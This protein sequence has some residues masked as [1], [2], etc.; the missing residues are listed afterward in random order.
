MNLRYFGGGGDDHAENDE[1]DD[2]EMVGLLADTDHDVDMTPGPM[3]PTSS[4]AASKKKSSIKNK[5]SRKRG[6]RPLAVM[7]SSANRRLLT[8]SPAVAACRTG[9]GILSLSVLIGLWIWSGRQ[10][11]QN[12]TIQ[13][14]HKLKLSNIRD[15]CLDVRCVVC[16]DSV[17]PDSFAVS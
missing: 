17:A 14:W 7:H 8:K 11:E 2:V 4:F 1:E 3:I 12:T 13:R 10:V 15:W 5:R 6:I 16:C 9:F